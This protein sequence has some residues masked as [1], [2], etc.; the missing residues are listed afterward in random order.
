MK[1]NRFICILLM[2]SVLLFAGC[3]GVTFSITGVGS[4]TTVE[5][6]NAEDGDLSETQY[7]SAGK[8]RSAQ[9]DSS[10]DKGMLQIDFV[11]VTVYHNNDNSEDVIPG[12]IVSSV[13][14]GPDES[15]RLPLEAGDYI[16]Q[17]TAIGDTNGTVVIDIV[18]N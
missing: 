12:D 8:N 5:V 7:F 15:Q 3:E 9:I 16:M 11:E 1:I 18:K 4:K 6:K 13:K 14:V 10:L 2:L 17:L